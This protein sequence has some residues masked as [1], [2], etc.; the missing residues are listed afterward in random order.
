MNPR[1]ALR[2]G[3]VAMMSWTMPGDNSDDQKMKY[4]EFPIAHNKKKVFQVHQFSVQNQ[5]CRGSGE[6]G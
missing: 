5:L 4:T 6:L 3:F 2:A 1:T